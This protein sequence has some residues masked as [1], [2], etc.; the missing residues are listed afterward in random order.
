MMYHQSFG[1]HYLPSSQVAAAAYKAACYGHH[2]VSS[3]SLSTTVFDVITEGEKMHDYFRCAV[4][5]RMSLI[6]DVQ[7]VLVDR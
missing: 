6:S 1:A 5:S 7:E 3:L 4:V 2:Q